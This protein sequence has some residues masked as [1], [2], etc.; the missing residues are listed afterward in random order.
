MADGDEIPIQD[1]LGQCHSFAGFFPALEDP[2]NKLTFMAGMAPPMI[3]LTSPER[4][5]I[6]GRE[7]GMGF[8]SEKES[9][10]GPARK[11]KNLGLDEQSPMANAFQNGH[12]PDVKSN[13]ILFTS[14]T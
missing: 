10:R 11:S 4:G 12:H 14:G 13:N 1:E 9:V 6:V 3:A 5:F 8:Q 2:D 7:S